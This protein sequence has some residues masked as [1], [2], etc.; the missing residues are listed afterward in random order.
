MDEILSFN[1]LFDPFDGHKSLPSDPC[2]RYRSELALSGQTETP[3]PKA[4]LHVWIESRRVD[5]PPSNR[6]MEKR[7]FDP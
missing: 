5:N 7:E 3:G 4:D 6:L 1:F 2:V